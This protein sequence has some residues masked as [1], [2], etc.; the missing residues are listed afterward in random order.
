MEL[1]GGQRTKSNES[2]DG[3]RT[4]E[5]DAMTTY[6]NHIGRTAIDHVEELTDEACRLRRMFLAVI[7]DL[8]DPSGHDGRLGP[9]MR[10][11]TI[12]RRDP[13]TRWLARAIIHVWSNDARFRVN[14]DIVV[15]ADL[16]Q[17][18]SKNGSDKPKATPQ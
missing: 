16:V 7:H 9:E 17:N 4:M 5:D 2:E 8:L 3:A 11:T 6:R 13:R 18:K 1:V 12:E 10:K 14:F 15:R